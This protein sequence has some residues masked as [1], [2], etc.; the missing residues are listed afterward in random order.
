MLPVDIPGLAFI[1]RMCE[2]MGEAAD[3]GLEDCGQSDCGGISRG[4]AFP[5]YK[6]PLQSVRL[7]YCHRCGEPSTKILD[8]DHEGR[9]GICDA[10]LKNL[11]DN[12]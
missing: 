1:C 3:K 8:V 2:R 10:C 4:R 6:G 12:E 9:L 5:L 7:N 11:L